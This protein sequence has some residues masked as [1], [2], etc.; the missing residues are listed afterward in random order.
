MPVKTSASRDGTSPGATPAN[1]PDAAI[2]VRN[3]S[4]VLA[5]RPLFSGLDLSLARGRKLTLRGPSG[6]GKST[7][8]HCLLGF[9][10]PAGGSIRICGQ[11]LD[12]DSVWRLRAR[13]AYV[14]QEPAWAPGRVSDILSRPFSFKINRQLRDRLDRIPELMDDLRLPAHLL[15]QE[16]ARLSGGERQRLALLA[17]LLLEREILLLDEATAALD[18]ET[19]QAVIR[20]LREK[21][22]PTIIAISHDRDGLGPEAETFYLGNAGA[23]K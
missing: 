11:E 23:G 7:F 8:L 20:L 14:P 10:R 3:L 16:T 1:A 15:N 9:V 12:G 18:Q 17:A 22:P 13:M 6:S 19:S 21:G 2:A 4:V 5:R